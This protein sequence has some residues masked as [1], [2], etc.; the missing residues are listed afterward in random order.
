[1]DKSDKITLIK[2]EL[3]VH[4]LIRQLHFG[5]AM[6]PA[7]D[8]LVEF[9][10]EG[11]AFLDC[12]E[13]TQRVL[14][15][16]NIT[17]VYS[18]SFSKCAQYKKIFFSSIKAIK[19][20]KLRFVLSK[21]LLKLP[22]T[23]RRLSNFSIRVDYNNGKYYY[24]KE[25]ICEND[26]MRYRCK[27]FLPC[28]LEKN[29]LYDVAGQKQLCEFDSHLPWVVLGYQASSNIVYEKT[30]NALYLRNPNMICKIKKYNEDVSNQLESDGL[31]FNT[32]IL[33][34][35]EKLY[36]KV[37]SCITKISFNKT[38]IIANISKATHNLST[39]TYSFCCMT[40]IITRDEYLFSNTNQHK[41][42]SSI[43]FMEIIRFKDEHYL[44][45]DP[46]AEIAK[47]EEENDD[48]VI[49]S[50]QPRAREE[51]RVESKTTQRIKQEDF[52]MDEEDFYES[53]SHYI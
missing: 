45:K 25:G 1:M 46:Y 5:L 24:V 39:N 19:P 16:D 18:T 35:I 26:F 2:Y 4:S 30:T 40:S 41:K 13:Y 20:L 32:D 8:V 52:Y 38:Q 11:I 31:Y 23:M 42:E 10:D 36:K 50:I 15:D 48:N 53:A 28:L 6:M 44:K 22:F 12:S 33:K 47:A 27:V 34:S 51:V 17:E 21:S 3:N 14:S 49:S 43:P 29:I 37:H 9:S 7:G